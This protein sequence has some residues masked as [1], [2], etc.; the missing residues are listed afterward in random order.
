MGFQPHLELLF[1]RDHRFSS[2]RGDTRMPSPHRSTSQSAIIFAIVL[3]LTSIFSASPV[4][5]QGKSPTSSNSPAGLSAK[6]APVPGGHSVKLSWKASVP[7]SNSPLDA[8]TGYNVYRSKQADMPL[9]AENKV[10]SLNGPITSYIDTDVNPGETWHY[11]ATAVSA[12]GKESDRSNEV[13]I[14]IP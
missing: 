11:V 8:I 13:T 4:D 10:K 7:A 1:L 9:T 3:G 14:T 12:R 6:S 2:D 5:D